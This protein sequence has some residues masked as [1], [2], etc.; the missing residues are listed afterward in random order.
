MR[1]ARAADA[2]A[3]QARVVVAGVMPHCAKPALQ[4][5]AGAPLFAVRPSAGQEGLGLVVDSGKGR[6]VAA[7]MICSTSSAPSSGARMVR[8]SRPDTE[9]RAVEPDQ[10]QSSRRQ[11]RHWLRLRALVRSLT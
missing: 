6:V 11:G 10:A 5:C 2:V 1:V 8:W 9:E 4:L 7:A 3:A